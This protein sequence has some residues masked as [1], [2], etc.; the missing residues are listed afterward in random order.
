MCCVA[1]TG[2][3]SSSDSGIEEP[4]IHGKNN[5]NYVMRLVRITLGTLSL[6]RIALGTLS[7]V[8][9]TLINALGKN[10][11]RYSFI[12]KNS[13]R[14]SVHGKNNSNKCAW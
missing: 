6:V 3:S 11:I 1:C 10:S 9:I 2:D 13:I 5:S 7:M 12:G 14:Y 8:R 4:S